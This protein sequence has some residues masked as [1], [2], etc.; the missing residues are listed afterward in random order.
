VSA[1]PPLRFSLAKTL[2]R[3]PGTLLAICLL[4]LGVSLLVLRSASLAPDGRMLAY[5]SRQ[6]VWVGIGLGAFFGVALVPYHWVARRSHLLYVAGL[7]ALALVFVLGTKVNGSRRWYS[8]GPV[9]VQPSEFMKYA[10]VVVLAHAIALRGAAGIRTWGGLAQAAAITGAPFLLVLAQPDLGTSLTYLPIAAAVVFAAGARLR[11]LA[12]IGGA[13][14]AALPLAW[15]FVLKD[16][17]KMRVRAFLDSEGQHALGGAYQTTQSV[18]AIGSGGPWGRGYMEGSQGTLGFL[19]E[20]HT[21]FVFGVI[22]EDFGLAGG[23]AVLALYGYLLCTLGRIAHETR[24]LE[25]RLIV[26]GV[27]AI[28]TVQVV[29]NAGMSMGITPVTGLTLPLV[30]YGGSSLVASM[31]GLGLVASVARHKRRNWTG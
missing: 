12:A 4:L 13:G 21:D 16:Y 8:L 18:I 31:L 17:Q 14:L 26:V 9:R 11:H 25:G 1:G 29:V 2:D 22:G 24:D 3:F 7:V 30:S 28:L 15:L 27:G 5:A 23:L 19:P 10:L 6:V 20:R